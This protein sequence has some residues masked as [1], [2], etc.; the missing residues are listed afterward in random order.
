MALPSDP[1]QIDYS[2]DGLIVG[3]KN[4][5]GIYLID[6]GMARHIP[7]METYTQIFSTT[8]P[9]V[10]VDI[11][12]YT[13][14]LPI[15]R[16]DADGA[17]NSSENVSYVGRDREGR[18]IFADPNSGSGFARRWINCPPAYQ[19]TFRGHTIWTYTFQMNTSGPDI[20][21]H[22]LDGLMTSDSS[23]AIY[24]HDQGVARH[25]PDSA[26]YLKLFRQFKSKGLTQNP[27]WHNTYHE[28][29]PLPKSSRLIVASS[30]TDQPIYLQDE[31]ENGNPIKRRIMNP[32][33]FN[34]YFFDW[35]KVQKISLNEVENMRNGPW[36]YCPFNYFKGIVGS[37]SIKV[38]ASYGI[39]LHFHNVTQGGKELNGS[40]YVTQGFS[41]KIN[42]ED[43]GCN[44]NDVIQVKMV[45][46]RID[47]FIASEKF[48][49]QS[50]C[51][52]V[53]NYHTAG[54][55][56]YWPGAPIQ[57][58]AAVLQGSASEYPT[59]VFDNITG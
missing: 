29:R 32:E 3:D 2:Q 22:E 31:D 46:P 14:G 47:S 39:Y 8:T 15:A 10:E 48:I 26:T 52:K 45:V 41:A 18:I 40:G 58:G 51:P 56:V 19:Y 4:G 33:A 21:Y 54:D 44:H 30:G 24:L 37:F 53:A 6:Q 55:L 38:T 23:G 7:D 34:Y 57:A 11:S 9:P 17:K 50:G 35:G 13:I 16:Y 59:P 42:P 49:F 36:I 5:K 28:G 20:L 43:Y 27:D 1:N 12:Q 25:I